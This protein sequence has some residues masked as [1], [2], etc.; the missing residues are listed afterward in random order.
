MSFILEHVSKT[1]EGQ[2]HIEDVSLAVEAGSFCVLL[3]PT[4]AG[5]TTLLRLMAGLDRPSG[6]RI[7]V[8]GVDVTRTDVRVRSVAM[9][10][11]QF[12]NYPSLTVFENIASPLRVQRRLDFPEIRRRV[13]ELAEM[14][15]LRSFLHRLPSELS[16]GQQQ[17]TALARALAKEADLILLDEPV[18]NLDYKLREQLRDDVRCIL[19]K[20]KTTVMYATADPTEALILGGQTAVVD[21]GRILQFGPTG[22]VYRN[23]ADQRVARIFGD[24]PMNLW[25]ACV[26]RESAST[27]LRLSSELAVPVPGHLSRLPLG[28][29]LIGIRPHH[30][31]DV[32]GGGSDA[33][34]SMTVELAELGGSSTRVHAHHQDVPLVVQQD[35]LRTYTLGETATLYVDPNLFFGFD[36]MG[37]LVAA[38]EDARVRD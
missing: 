12:V 23:P 15:S 26:T 10:Y 30:F 34:V 36:T 33:P 19:A 38:P 17:R 37:R 3:G 16:G 24:P 22:Y 1:V 29:V 28:E 4:T 20:R 35:G 21:R 25:P 8:N 6:G 7:L 27:T 14:L 2:V 31:V 18:A 5:K 13:E 11:Q 9:V 32:V